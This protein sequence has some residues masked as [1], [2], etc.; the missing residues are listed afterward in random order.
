MTKKPSPKVRLNAAWATIIAA[1]IGLIGILLVPVLN[2]MFT[3][4]TSD[5][6]EFIVKIQRQDSPTAISNAAVKVSMAGQIADGVSGTDGIARVFISSEKVGK[7]ATLTVSADGYE[8]MVREIQR[9]E[10]DTTPLP[11]Q[12]KRLQ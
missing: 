5:L 9:L 10:V 8:T 3:T 12:L 6:K 7:P 1:L 2:T 4:P 11:I